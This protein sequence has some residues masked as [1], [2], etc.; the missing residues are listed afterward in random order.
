MKRILIVPLTFI[1]IVSICLSGCSNQ[2]NAIDYSDNS[3]WSYFETDTTD[4]AADVFLYVRLY[5][6]AQMTHTI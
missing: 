5:I 3:N 4:K 6:P 1:L 2:T